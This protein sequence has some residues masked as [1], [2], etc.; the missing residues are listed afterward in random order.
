MPTYSYKCSQCDFS[1]DRWLK[2]SEANKVDH[3]PN[4]RSKTLEKLVS[5]PAFKLKGTGWY[6]T[7]FK[8]GQQQ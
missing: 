4:C 3:C 6:Q 7:D 8:G 2:V 1:E 5:A